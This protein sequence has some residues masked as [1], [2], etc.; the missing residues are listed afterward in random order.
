MIEFLVSLGPWAWIIGGVVLLVLEVLAPG[1]I[2]LWLGVS[3]IVVGLIGFVADISWQAEFIIFGILAVACVVIYKRY[4]RGRSEAS[5]RPFLNQRA[6]GMVGRTF[7]LQEAIRHGEG[8]VR[9]NDTVWR[10]RGPDL[11]KGA[12]VRVVSTDGAMLSVEAHE[13]G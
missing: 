4:V 1:Q 11:P 2:F 6:V 5:D 13:A 12:S 10:V 8:K 3:A 9:I 7:T